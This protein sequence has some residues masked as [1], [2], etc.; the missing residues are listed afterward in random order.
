MVSVTAL[1]SI[2]ALGRQAQTKERREKEKL[3]TKIK[4]GEPV[5]ELE[6]AGS[7]DI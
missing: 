1:A 2:F 4:E 3:R 5:E 6:R 7:E